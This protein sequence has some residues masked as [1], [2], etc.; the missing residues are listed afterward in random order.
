MQ[1]GPLQPRLRGREPVHHRGAELQDIGLAAQPLP[2]LAPEAWHTRQLVD[3]GGVLHRGDQPHREMV[4]E[5]LAHT[6]Q[7]HLG[8]NAQSTQP[9]AIANARQLQQ[10]G[11]VDGAGADHHL[12]PRHHLAPHTI[13]QVLHATGAAALDQNAQRLRVGPHIQVAAPHSRAQKAASR[14]HAPAVVDAALEIA[15][16]LLVGAVVVRVARQPLLGG[17]VQK[18]LAN[19]VR[20]VR[21][22][23]L[24]R[25]VVAA[26]GR[27]ATIDKML[28]ALEVRQHLVI[29]PA[30]IALRRP[31]VEILALA[32]VVD[33]AIDGGGAAQGLAL[34][35][36]NAPAAGAL[37]RLGAELPGHRRVEDH[38]DETG[39]QLEVG[40]VVGRAGFEHAD[41][42]RRVLAQTGGD[43]G[44]GRTAADHHI[45]KTVGCRRAHAWAPR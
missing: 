30:G 27:I 35:Q 16:A 20:P 14:A 34:G 39:R 41:A 7:M 2:G 8:G 29:G 33:Q 44:T 21:Q 1:I 12:A 28:A 45:V 25:P 17:A 22:A 24:E 36:R 13:L 18:G 3:R 4:L 37:G 42:Q 31:A 38:L 40:P 43:D 23:D 26:Q 5:V 15:H 11:R 19:R 6:G 9:L 32:P 10:L